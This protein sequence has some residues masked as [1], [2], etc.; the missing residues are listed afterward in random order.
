MQALLA[1]GLPVVTTFPGTLPPLGNITVAGADN[2]LTFGLQV[3]G[4][5][6][7]LVFDGTLGRPVNTTETGKSLPSSSK[8]LPCT[9]PFESML[10]SALLCPADILGTV[11][12]YAISK[13]SNI[14]YLGMLRLL[15][16]SSRNSFNT[17]G[18]ILAFLMQ[19]RLCWCCRHQARCEDGQR[20]AVDLSLGCSGPLQSVRLAVGSQLSMCISRQHPGRLEPD[21]NLCLPHH[22][23]TRTLQQGEHV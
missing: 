5:S 7:Q 10:Q 12:P 19:P 8:M 20:R 3:E 13:D 18:G 15:C 9:S 14:A 22:P 11:M 17:S 23:H 6:A 4:S 21:P 1:N 16:H 2:G